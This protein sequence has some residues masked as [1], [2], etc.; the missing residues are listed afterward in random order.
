MISAVS[1]NTS[2][3]A[4]AG[5]IAAPP[6]RPSAEEMFK[7]LDADGKGYLSASDLESAFVSIS[8]AGSDAADKAKQVFARI[9][10]D[11]D[12]KVTENE[13]KAA[14][15]QQGPTPSAAPQKPQGAGGPPPAAT[16]AS[17]TASTDS[18]T[19]E[20]ADANQDGKVTQQ[21][22]QTYD[23]QQAAK[24]ALSAD[25]STGSSEV[26]LVAAEAVK[27]YDAVALAA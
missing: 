25:T 2:S 27:T 20:A 19:Y 22:Q 5:T 15:P 8:A 13:F 18:E 23:A 11:G 3:T 10:T 6:P 9:D 14:E 1:T 12:G 26:S 17:A 7:K 16:G 21:E 24:Q 4:S